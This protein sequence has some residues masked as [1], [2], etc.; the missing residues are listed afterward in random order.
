MKALEHVKV[1]GHNNA[2]PQ[3][4]FL[5]DYWLEEADDAT[6]CKKALAF[7]KKH[8]PGNTADVVE[9]GGARRCP[10][11]GKILWKRE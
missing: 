2:I 6:L 3:H 1:Y 7:F 5:T 10:G 11:M 8:N 9:I 4:R